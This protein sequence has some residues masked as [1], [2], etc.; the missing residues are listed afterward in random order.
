MMLKHKTAAGLAAAAMITTSLAFT[1]SAEGK[2]VQA[3]TSKSIVLDSAVIS[4]VEVQP[5]FTPELMT[6]EDGKT[7]FIAEDGSRV[8]ISWTED[9]VNSDGSILFSVVA[10]D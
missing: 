5:G 3:D 7:Y 1:A 9:G 4:S 6:D 10:A 2:D 8:Y